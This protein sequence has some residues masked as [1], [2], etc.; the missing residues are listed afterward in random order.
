[1]TDP[2]VNI[3]QT[4]WHIEDQLTPSP[5]T[6][7]REVRDIRT[8]AEIIEKELNFNFVGLDIR[9]RNLNQ[10]LAYIENNDKF[11]I[12]I[13]DYNWPN[14]NDE[15]HIKFEVKY[16]T[17]DPDFTKFGLNTGYWSQ[18]YIEEFIQPEFYLTF[19]PS[20]RLHEWNFVKS[21]IASFIR[22]RIIN[23][24]KKHETFTKII[25]WIISPVKNHINFNNWKSQK[26]IALNFYPDK[27]NDEELIHLKLED[28]YVVHENNKKKYSILIKNEDYKKIRKFKDNENV[29]FEL[30][31]E[32]ITEF[33]F[34]L[35]PIIGLSI[36]GFSLLR[37]HQL[38]TGF[39]A[40]SN[41]ATSYVIILISFAVFYFTYHR[42]GYNIPAPF[43]VYTSLFFLAI[44]L[45]VEISCLKPGLVP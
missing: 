24:I 15:H 1:M 36:I 21:R 35:F 34:L 40:Y 30:S 44:S 14:I 10:E 26:R 29:K 45:I 38:Y 17:I 8:K 3:L 28:P 33:K 19:P 25:K 41:V 13:S 6:I 16:T 11:L 22:V 9:A 42:D 43:I 27:N 31:Y 39:T 20:I 37:I 12:F 18:V 32:A 2:T 7:I 5:G 23:P 4:W